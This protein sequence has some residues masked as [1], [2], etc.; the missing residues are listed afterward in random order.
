[1]NNDLEQ[2]VLAAHIEGKRSDLVSLYQEAAAA[3]PSKDEYAFFLTQAYVFA[4][5]TAHP[6]APVL[7]DLLVQMERETPL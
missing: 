3:A 2:R 5:E 7:R 1:M 4:L 6:D